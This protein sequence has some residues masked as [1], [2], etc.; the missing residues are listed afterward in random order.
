MLIPIIIAATSTGAFQPN[1]FHFQSEIVPYQDMN[2]AVI[3]TELM[4][5][6]ATG[7]ER[8]HIVIRFD[9]PI[10]KVTKEM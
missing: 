10:S 2:I 8:M 3:A 9:K 5:L 7:G 4:K 1:A 6:E